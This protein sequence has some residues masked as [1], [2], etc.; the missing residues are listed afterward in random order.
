MRSPGGYAV[1][2]DH[3]GIREWDTFTCCHCQRVVQVMT[4][5]DPSDLGGFCRMCMKNICGPCA[6]LGS[7]TPFE[8]KLEI[9]ERKTRLHEA[10]GLVLR[11][12][13]LWCLL[14]TTAQAAELFLSW[15]DASSDE[16]SF[17]V[18]RATSLGGSYANI[19]TLAVGIT[20]YRDTLLT[21]D[22]EYCY[23]IRACN[24]AGCSSYIGPVCQ[25]AKQLPESGEFR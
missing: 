11:V 15:T 21:A 22:Q 18:E 4:R 8:K 23:K 24:S 17:E 9:Y 13:V 14:S 3:H 20:T 19:A 16:T 7:C 5:C 2:S 10:M 25:R 6:D 12:F 1:I